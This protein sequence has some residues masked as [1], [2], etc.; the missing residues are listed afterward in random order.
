MEI[1][2]LR[3]NPNHL[4]VFEKLDFCKGMQTTYLTEPL[5]AGVCYGLN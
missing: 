2:D 5:A 4:I 3:K 1:I